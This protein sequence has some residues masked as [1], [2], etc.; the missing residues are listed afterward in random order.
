MLKLNL[1][2][3]DTVMEGYTPIDRK[4]GQEVF[5]LQYEDNSVDE[6]RASHVLEH[7]RYTGGGVWEVLKHWAQKLRPGGVL[8]VAVPDFEKIARGYVAFRD[9]DTTAKMNTSG[10]ILGGQVDDNDFHYALFDRESLS[11]IMTKAG[12]VDIKEWK[13]EIQDCAA[14]PISLNLQGTKVANP[15]YQSDDIAGTPQIKVAGLL[16][17]PR[18][19]F[20]DNMYCAAQAFYPLGIRFEKGTGVFW[21]QVLSNMIE[22]EVKAGTDYVISLD[23]DTWFK[24]E[25]VIRLCQHMVA[26]PDIDAVV[27]IQLGRE[28]NTPLLGIDSTQTPDENNEIL[29][30]VRKFQKPLVPIMTGH[31]GLTIFRVSA[32]AKLKKPW[33]HAVPGPDGGWHKG[34]KDADIAFWHNWHESGLKAA[35]ATDVY[36]GHLQRVCSFASKPEDNWKPVHVYMIDVDKGRNIPEHCIPKVEQVG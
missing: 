24:K 2:A 26:N 27:P 13:S 3:G 23:Y 6:I 20:L 36:I 12:L 9:G 31:F 32:F 21:S 16:S 33:F 19:G 34:R 10:Y 22:N 35:I 25:H 17:A 1:G 8:K 11:L 5:P 15:P 7:F 29:V 18:L 4:F 14:L 28:V 30:N